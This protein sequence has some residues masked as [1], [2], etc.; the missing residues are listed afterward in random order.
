MDKKIMNFDKTSM[1]K[2]HFKEVMEDLKNGKKTYDD[3]QEQEKEYIRLHD[4]TYK[5]MFL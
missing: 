1:T 4:P 5:Q 3:L 2:E